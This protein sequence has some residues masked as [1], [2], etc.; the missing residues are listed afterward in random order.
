VLRHVAR[1]RNG[2]ATVREWPGILLNVVNDIHPGQGLDVDPYPVGALFVGAA[3]DVELGDLVR[4]VFEEFED[5][6]FFGGLRFTGRQA[7]TERM[8][9]L[10]YP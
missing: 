1:H 5:A 10:S 8:L 3:A 6:L 2:N 9:S 4:A 7:F